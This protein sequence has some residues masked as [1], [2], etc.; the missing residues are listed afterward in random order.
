MCKALG[1]SIVND[2]DTAD[3][4]G[5]R[6]LRLALQ[7]VQQAESHLCAWIDKSE[8]RKRGGAEVAGAEVADLNIVGAKRAKC[9]SDVLNAFEDRSSQPVTTA[10]NNVVLQPPL[11]SLLA[12]AES[13]VILQPPLQSLVDKQSLPLLRR[14]KSKPPVPPTLCTQDTMVVI[15]ETQI[16]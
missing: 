16:T 7:C 6:E 14:S 1:Q 5:V 2:A 8:R 13:N 12:T 11:Q 10:A 3:I 15:E 4:L 9:M